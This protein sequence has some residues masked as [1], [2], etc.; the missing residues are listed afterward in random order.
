MADEDDPGESIDPFA[1]MPLFGDLSRALSGQGPLNWD[2]A[3]QFAVLA[4]NGGGLL[5]GTGVSTSANVDPSV[6]IKYA[7]SPTSPDCTSVT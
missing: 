2:A 3:R 4:A 6:R 1:G 5:S 7:S